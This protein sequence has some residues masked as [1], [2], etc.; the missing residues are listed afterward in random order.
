MTIKDVAARAGVSPALVSAALGGSSRTVRMSEATRLRVE[1][2][3]LETG[4]RA[5]HAAKALRSARTG[6]IAAVVPKIA[7]PV[8]ELAIRGIQAAAEEHGDVLLL[9]D[10][11]WIEPG[12]HLMARMAGSGMVDGF[13]VRATEWGSE[14]SDELSRRGLPFVIL[15]TP[16]ADAPTSVWTDDAAGVRLATSHLIGLGHRDIALVGGVNSPTAARATGYRQAMDA[17]G[18]RVRPGRMQL[19]GFDPTV[20]DAAVR[21]VMSEPRPPTAMVIDNVTA[22]PGAL[23]ALLDLGVRVPQDLSLVVFQDLPAAD[24]FRP[25][26]TTVRMPLAEAGRRGYLT[27]RKMINGRSG[28]SSLVRRPAPKLIDRGSTAALRA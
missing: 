9:A 7:N 12:S 11:T 1:Q 15:Q 6:V 23:A 18:L 5:N 3:A 4:Y 22:A 19:L 21:D 16:V 28:A 2:A 14:R 10:S 17:A 24:H 20:I 8:F 26:P 27:L 13:L 25:A